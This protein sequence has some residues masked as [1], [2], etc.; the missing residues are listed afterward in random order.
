MAKITFAQVEFKVAKLNSLIS[1]TDSNYYT[2]TDNK[3]C[4][5]TLIGNGE[6]IRGSYDCILSYL[7]CEPI[8]DQIMNKINGMIINE[9]DGS[10]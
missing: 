2:V 6:N 5:C 3:D 10:I 8:P 4:T 1:L 7:G 9:Q